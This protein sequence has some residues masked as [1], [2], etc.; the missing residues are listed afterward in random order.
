SHVRSFPQRMLAIERKPALL[1]L[2]VAAVLA[3]VLELGT[4]G[5]LTSFLAGVHGSSETCSRAGLV[6]FLV[7]IAAGR[8]V[9]GLAVK[10]RLML[11]TMAALFLLSALLYAGLYQ[12]ELGRLLFAIVFLAGFFTSAL[13]PLIIA[14]AA[15]AAREAAGSVIGVLKLAIPAGGLVGSLAISWAAHGHGLRDALWL[16]PAAAVL[17]FCAILLT[18]RS[19][20]S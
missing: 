3:V 16:I 11:W 20:R 13:F 4:V 14:Q 19:L 10:R 2:F 18:A 9:I 6:V 7:G 8:L 15:L 1:L 12:V 17:G 5:Y